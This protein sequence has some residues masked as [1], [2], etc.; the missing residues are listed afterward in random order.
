V[1]AEQELCLVP[2]GIF[3]DNHIRKFTPAEVQ[4]ATSF[5]SYLH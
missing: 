3:Q 4:N 5:E 1:D 2:Y